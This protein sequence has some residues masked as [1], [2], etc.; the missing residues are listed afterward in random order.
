[1]RSV[2]L[3]SSKKCLSFV[4][5]LQ[6]NRFCC[7]KMFKLLI[8]SGN[9]VAALDINMGCPKPFSIAGGMGAALLSEPEK[10]RGVHY[11]LILHLC[12]DISC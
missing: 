9:D 4:F 12:E 6:F 3:K 11:F 7:I 10:A 8:S 1:M 2:S 5:F